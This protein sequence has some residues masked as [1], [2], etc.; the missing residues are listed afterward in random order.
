MH[1]FFF[2]NLYSSEF[3]FPFLKPYIVPLT[4]LEVVFI[5]PPTERLKLMSRWHSADYVLSSGCAG[6]FRTDHKR[7]G[8]AK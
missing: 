5:S 7:G 6:G 8:F 2:S 4:L 1:L 3:E